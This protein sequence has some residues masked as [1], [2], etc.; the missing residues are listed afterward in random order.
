MPAKRTYKPNGALTCH[1][2]FLQEVAAREADA[3][4]NKRPPPLSV[5]QHARLR[6]RLER[7]RFIKPKYA[8]E[9]E[10]NVSGMLK[11]WR[12]FVCTVLPSMVFPSAV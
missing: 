2:D 4:V 5:A 1:A 12:R 9:T 3:Q 11:K 8:L 7:V 10:I 6:E